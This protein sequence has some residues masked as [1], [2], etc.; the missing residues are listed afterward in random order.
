MSS[1]I[2][3]F[4]WLFFWLSTMIIVPSVAKSKGFGS[5]WLWTIVAI[6][7]P[8]ISL[9]MVLL[10]PRAKPSDVDHSTNNTTSD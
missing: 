4:F 3:W 5:P 10:W 6:L 7:V 9:L 2:T 8:V 1:D